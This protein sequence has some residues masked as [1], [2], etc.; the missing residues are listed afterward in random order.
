VESHVPLV[1]NVV[2]YAFHAILEAS[3]M[4]TMQLQ[5]ALP[6]QRGRISLL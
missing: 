2:V 1:I 4:T 6:A 3:T 5:L